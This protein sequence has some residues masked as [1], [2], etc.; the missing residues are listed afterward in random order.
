MDQLKDQLAREVRRL[1]SEWE[2]KKA[3]VHGAAT[4]YEEEIEKLEKE[5]PPKGRGQKS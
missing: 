5:P 2:E 1:H 4:E 3:A